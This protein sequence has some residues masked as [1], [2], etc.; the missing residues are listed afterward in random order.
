MK[1]KCFFVKAVPAHLLKN[2]CD[3]IRGSRVIPKRLDDLKPEDIK[4]FPQM[5]KWFVLKSFILIKNFL[6]FIS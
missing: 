5:F 1:E 3:Q 4:K 2:V 6:K